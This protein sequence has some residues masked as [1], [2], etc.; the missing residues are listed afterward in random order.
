MKIG[1]RGVRSDL[2][3]GLLAT[4]VVA[5]TACAAS[6]DPKPTLEQ[7]LESRKLQLGASV[8]SIPNYRVDGWSS[9][10]SEHVI[11]NDGAA[12][13]YLLTLGRPC[14]DLVGAETIGF[15]T[16]VTRL[17]ALDALVVQSPIGPQRCQ[18]KTI[19]RLDR[20][21]AAD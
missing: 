11:L 3:R 18:I 20:I 5:M 12:N 9:L 16:T 17:T 7:R 6:T 19:H 10:D 8:D 4:V 1:V 2:A 13:R 15:T 21:K 14:N